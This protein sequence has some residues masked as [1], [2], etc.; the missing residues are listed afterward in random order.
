MPNVKKPSK[1]PVQ[2]KAVRATR[3]KRAPRAKATPRDPVMAAINRMYSKSAPLLVGEALLFV[4]AAAIL[5]FKPVLVLT[6]FTYIIGIA[7]LLFGLY[8]MISGF[9][10]SNDNGGG[11]IDVVFGLINIVLGLLFVV[12]PAGSLVSVAYIFVVLFF[13]KALRVLVFAINL[14]RAR[15]GHYILTLIGG[16]VLFALAI[17]LFFFPLGTFIAMTYYLAVLM[18]IYAVADIYMF[19]E[20]SRVKMLVSD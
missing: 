20:L 17:A 16:I 9:I 1:K 15:F 5:F 14:A 11:G 2:K 4:V 13:F 8:R 3:V 6:I 10:V 12:Y 18:L 19:V 7:L